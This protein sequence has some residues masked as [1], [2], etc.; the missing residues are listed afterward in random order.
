[1]SDA[2]L[3]LVLWIILTFGGAWAIYAVL[4]LVSFLAADV[5]DKLWVGALGVVLTIVA[6]LAWFIFAA[7]HAIEQIVSVV[8]IASGAGG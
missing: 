4:G 2:I 5:F 3:W 8:Q 6:A 7:V 1:M